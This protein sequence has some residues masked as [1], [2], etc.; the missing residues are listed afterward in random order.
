MCTF[1]LF[2]KRERLI[3][4]NNNKNVCEYEHSIE[5][6][7]ENETVEADVGYGYYCYVLLRD[8]PILHDSEVK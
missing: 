7:L 2:R 4:D 8:S 1:A 3:V 5:L 6:R